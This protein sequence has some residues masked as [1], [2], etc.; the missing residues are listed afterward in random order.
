MTKGGERPLGFRGSQLGCPGED[1]LMR[2]RVGA[3]CAVNA[4]AVATLLAGCGGAGDAAADQPVAPSSTPTA[5]STSEPPSPTAAPE[6]EPEPE[7]TAK[8]LSRF[9]DQAPVQA[10]RAWAS[11]YATAVNDGDRRLRLLAPLT[12]AE[13]LDRMVGYGVED[14]GLLYPGPLPFTPVG[15]QV[16]GGSAE[17]PMCL[18]AEG[19]ALDPK[20][21][22]PV[23]PRL[24]AEGKLTLTRVGG[25]WSIEDLLAEDDVDCSR[26]S[27]RGRG[28]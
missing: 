26:V 24:I 19:F 12:T 2:R 10:A 1:W 16:Q 25:Q 28:W 23:Q 4:I 6:T 13:G 14:A 3:A 27:V 20:T 17:V 21:K 11:A 15:V 9:E 22:L 18:W 8:P 7:R 5:T